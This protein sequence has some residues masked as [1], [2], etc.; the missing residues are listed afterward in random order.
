MHDTARKDFMTS[1]LAALACFACC[2]E[3]VGSVVGRRLRVGRASPRMLDVE[4]LRNLGPTGMSAAVCL[5]DMIPGVPTQPVAI[6]TGALFGFPEGLA[7]VCF[8]QACATAAAVTLARS[9]AAKSILSKAEDALSTPGPLKRSLDTI[10]ATIDSQS[11]IGVFTT[12]VG[13]RQ[14]PII[15]FSLGNYY[16][17]LF[18]RAP[19]VSVLAGTLVGCLPLNALW[20]YV[21]ATTGDALN[22]ILNGEKVDVSAI[23][24]SPAGETLEAVGGLATAAL[25][26]VLVSAL[27]KAQE[28]G[29]ETLPGDE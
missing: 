14:S 3:G 13:V 12:I 8:G 15:P 20:V 22:Q 25:A 18:T 28:A 29:A 23:L 16:L 21:G 7:C 9:P 2:V 19:L 27:R 5:A 26:V 10:A 11:A 6:A 4:T 17:G 24:S 1:K